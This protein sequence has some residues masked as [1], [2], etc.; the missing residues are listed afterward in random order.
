MLTTYEG[1][2]EGLELVSKNFGD[3]FNS[4]VLKGDGSEVLRHLSIFFFR[5]KH[6]VGAIQSLN[7]KGVSVEG[8][9]KCKEIR[10]SDSPC[11]F[12]KQ[13]A[14]SIRPRTSIRVHMTVSMMDLSSI[15]RS[16]Q[17]A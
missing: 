2:D 13:R 11:G 8:V 15:K 4:G 17:V 14:K 3:T 10:R 16:I 12:E 9:K 7:I 6:N 5:K 1:W